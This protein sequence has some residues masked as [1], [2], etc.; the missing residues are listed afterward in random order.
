MWYIYP[1]TRS[2]FLAVLGAVTKEEV[3]GWWLRHLYEEKA[4]YWSRG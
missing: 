3:D 4:D 1:P 2:V